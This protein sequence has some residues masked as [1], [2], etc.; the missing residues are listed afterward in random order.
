MLTS[1][2]MGLTLGDLLL[3]ETWIEDF[4]VHFRSGEFSY[5][6]FHWLFFLKE[7]SLILDKGRTDRMVSGRIYFIHRGIVFA[8]GV[9]FILLQTLF[10]GCCPS[11]GGEQSSLI[12]C[13]AAEPGPEL[14]IHLIMCPDST[15]PLPSFYAVAPHWRLLLSSYA[16]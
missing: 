6:C 1:G 7:R 4:R 9:C 11:W 10:G 2:N 3:N 16:L 8:P 12:C 14:G 13:Q 5:P 15:R